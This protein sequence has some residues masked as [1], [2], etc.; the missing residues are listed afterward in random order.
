MANI[1]YNPNTKYGKYVRRI[2]HIDNESDMKLC[3]KHFHI[4][5]DTQKNGQY[6]QMTNMYV[7]SNI[8]TVRTNGQY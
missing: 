7:Q 1:F 5:N 8:L 2:F 3:I 6:V 4:D